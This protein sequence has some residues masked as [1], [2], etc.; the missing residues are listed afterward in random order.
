MPKIFVKVVGLHN[1]FNKKSES[2]LNLSSIKSD[3]STSINKDSI[4]FLTAT[5]KDNQFGFQTDSKYIWAQNDL[6]STIDSSGGGS[7][8]PGPKGDKGD[9]GEQGPQGIQGEQGPKGDKGDPGES[10]EAGTNIN[11]SNGVISTID[12]MP[13]GSIILW[14]SNTLPDGWIL[15]NGSSIG[16][17]AYAD[18]RNILNNSVAPNI[19]GISE[20][21]NYIIKYKFCIPD[22]ITPPV[23]KIYAAFNDYDG[24][25]LELIELNPGETPVY[26]GKE[27]TR[28]S[29]YNTETDLWTEYTFIG[30]SP[31]IGPIN[32]DT[33]YIAQYSEQSYRQVTKYVKES[34]SDI[35]STKKYI[36]V[37]DN[38]EAGNIAINADWNTNKYMNIYTGT[39][40][41][42]TS[43][44]DISEFQI[45]SDIEPSHFLSLE[46]NG[47]N[48][49]LKDLDDNG[50]LVA[51]DSNTFSAKIYS[52]PTNNN[53][54]WK[55]NTDVTGIY[56]QNVGQTTRIIQYNQNASRFA[57]YK[58]T[59]ANTYLFY[60]STGKEYVNRTMRVM[61]A[62]SPNETIYVSNIQFIKG[63]P[64]PDDVE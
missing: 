43:I 63:K 23:G 51:R 45:A 19:S 56:I 61:R 52:T 7:G 34:I 25:Q 27:P 13:I 33:T 46:Y 39:M 31:E 60:K 6:Y 10:Y 15:C 54:L 8:I 50:Y 4:L 22:S 64:E 40:T 36:L 21:I 30:W 20:T 53:A 44:S 17:N 14:A 28:E 3:V 59:M 38:T 26:L 58:S 12:R 11:I 32:E 57:P 9:P 1:V 42:K 55:L 37:T 2:S 62:I 24:S 49:A 18:L 16:G 5:E 29:T 47:N 41:E 48:Y 35:D